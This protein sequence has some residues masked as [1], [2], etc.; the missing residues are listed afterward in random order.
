MAIP[1]FAFGAM[2][3]LGCVTYRE[4]AL[5]LDEEIATSAEKMRVLDVIGHELAHMWFGDLVT[6]KWWNGIWLNEAFA[7]FMEM[8]ATDAFRPEW[9][10]WLEFAA[11]ERPWAFKTD[12]LGRHQAGGVRGPVSRAGGGGCSTA[13]PMGRARLCSG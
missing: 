3:N 1:D 4:S 5:L 6:M 8:K 7:T 9:K 12:E 13:L 2:E 10:R 11:A